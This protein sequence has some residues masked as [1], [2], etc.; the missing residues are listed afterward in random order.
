[1]TADLERALRAAYDDTAGL[2][3]APPGPL[4]AL[5]RRSPWAAPVA[6]A[7]AV[8]VLVGGVYVASHGAHP[9]GTPVPA[10]PTTT[11]TGTAPTTSPSSVSQG[12]TASLRHTVPPGGEKIDLVGP[13][14]VREGTGA[15][16]VDLGSRPAG[17]NAVAYD[18]S[19]L[20]AGSFSEPF[21]T[22]SCDGPGHV[23]AEPVPLNARDVSAGQH[24]FAYTGTGRYRV[25]IGWAARTIVPLATNARG[26]TYG[27][28][29]FHL[30]PDLVSVSME[31]GG[32]GYVLRT[33]LEGDGPPRTPMTTSAVPRKI[34][35]YES[36]GVTVIGEFTIGGGQASSGG[37]APAG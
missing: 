16:T 36:D 8:A 30:E 19:C 9:D 18:V 20:S 12:A 15:I 35:V 26:Q 17:A 2:P 13:L 25:R 33:D 5:P 4:P 6:T 1:M 31:N 37:E 34:P 22:M 29:A 11:P 24:V 7:A 14:V 23:W 28:M 32:T 10:A 3:I 21:G 27:S